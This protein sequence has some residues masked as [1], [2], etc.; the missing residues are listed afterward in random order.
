MRGK[1]IDGDGSLKDILELYRCDTFT[2]LKESISFFKREQDFYDQMIT[3]KFH[4]EAIGVVS[5]DWPKNYNLVFVRATK[6]K[7]EIGGAH[8]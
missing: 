2:F 8:V 6:E 1:I 4:A 5:F 7:V 3:S